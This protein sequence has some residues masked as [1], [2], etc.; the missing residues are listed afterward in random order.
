MN[1]GA[2]NG[3]E[4]EQKL[5][6]Q[7]ESLKKEKDLANAALKDVI[8]QD[9]QKIAVLQKQ[10]EAK[11]ELQ[12]KDLAETK[13][14]VEK[15]VAQKAQARGPTNCTLHKKVDF[16]DISVCLECGS[17]C[18]EVNRIGTHLLFINDMCH[19]GTVLQEDLEVEQMADE[20]EYLQEKLEKK[21]R[22]LRRR[23]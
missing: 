11:E 4:V 16:D 18:S 6:K 22:S 3:G 9:S 14:L 8:A 5:L 19:V 21:G 13:E 23:R 15:L 20:I 7:V 12:Q 1:S 10:Q 2:G 17:G